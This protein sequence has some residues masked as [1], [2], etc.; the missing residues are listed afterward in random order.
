MGGGFRFGVPPS[1]GL[2][3][4]ENER[5]G[6]SGRLFA[7]YHRT[8]QRV[9][10]RARMTTAHLI[11]GL[12]Q[13]SSV[14]RFFLMDA[15]CDHY[16]C[17]CLA[18]GRCRCRTVH[19]LQGRWSL[20]GPSF[21]RCTGEGRLCQESEFHCSGAHKSGLL[22]GF[23]ARIARFVFRS[24]SSLAPLRTTLSTTV[25]YFLDAHESVQF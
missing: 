1:G 2:V 9:K 11:N 25:W 5:L 17:R 18:R 7:S 4:S 3:C 10:T 20:S 6:T 12:P 8:S 14:A 21:H 24:C 19:P 16:S 23:R 13:S 15:L 22:L